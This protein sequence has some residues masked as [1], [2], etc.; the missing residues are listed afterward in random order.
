VALILL[1]RRSW[2]NRATASTYAV[3]LVIGIGYTIYSEWLNTS[4][5]AAWAYSKLMPV[6]PGL[7]TGLSPLLQWLV[8]PTL[9]MWLALGHA[10][11]TRNTIR[12]CS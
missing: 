2:P 3:N 6:L 5:R 10:P 11:W 12:D 1:G 4:V 7:G 9:A 8:V